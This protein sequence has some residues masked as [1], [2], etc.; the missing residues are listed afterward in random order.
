MILLDLNV[1]LFMKNIE[2]TLTSFT[3]CLSRTVQCKSPHFLIALK[4][5]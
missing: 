5:W 3:E 1:L 2:Y 4:I